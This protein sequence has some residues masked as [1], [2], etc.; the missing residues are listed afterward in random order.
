MGVMMTV[1]M[2]ST[3]YVL[4]YVA[5]TVTQSAETD[6]VYLESRRQIVALEQAMRL[7][8]QQT[9]SEKEEVLN[10]RLMS[11]KRGEVNDSLWQGAPFLPEL[12]F[13]QARALFHASPVFTFIR[14][15]PKGGLLHVHFGATVSLDWF[16]TH[17]TYRR[18]CYVCRRPDP[19]GDIPFFL[20]SLHPPESR[21]DCPWRLAEDDRRDYASAQQ[22]DA[23]LARN[24]SL[25]VDHPASVFPSIRAVWQRFELYF[26]GLLPTVNYRPVFTAYLWQTMQEAL[27]DG[28]QYIELRFTVELYDLEGTYS[29]EAT[30]EIVQ[31]VVDSFRHQNPDFIGV[32]LIISSFKRK[33][34][35]QQQE[36]VLHTVRLRNKY[37]DLVL[38]FD[39][40]QHEDTAPSLLQLLE[41]LRHPSTQPPNPP[42]PF[43]FHAGETAWTELTDQN[44]VDAVLLNT[45]R[46]GHGYAVLRHPWVCRQVK[47]RGIALEIS[48]VSNQVLKLVTDLRNHPGTVMLSRDYP[49]VISSDDPAAWGAR[50]LS[51]DFYLTFMALASVKDDLRVLKQLAINSIQYSGLQGEE[52]SR[53]LAQWERAYDRFVDQMYD[54][55][56]KGPQ[57]ADSADGL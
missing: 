56:T 2:T 45:S 34:L 44:L 54:R 33:T 49:V 39:L 35:K 11:W 22:Y 31:E 42:L 8:N 19:N 24:L 37:P 51:H 28:V 27:D 16:V 50:P 23:D 9:L 18:H 46:I 57:G 30:V 52:K 25:A 17:V 7:G 43:F 47:E 4:T 48:P 13:F 12:H 20:F 10:Q 55:Y 53:G 21:P 3:I 1:V 14:Q 29:D 41:V 5:A 36:A 40:I 32:K 15:M 38:G 26:V 6:D